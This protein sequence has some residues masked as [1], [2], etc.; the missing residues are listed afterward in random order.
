[1]VTMIQCFWVEYLDLLPFSVL[2]RYTSPGPAA[3]DL[4]KLLPSAS[5]HHYEPAHA[6]KT[7]CSSGSSCRSIRH[8]D[9]K[10]QTESNQV[11]T[12]EASFL[13]E[14]KSHICGN[15]DNPKPAGQDQNQPA[16]VRRVTPA[17]GMQLR[18]AT[19]R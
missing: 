1:M 16:R 5:A 17:N 3:Q 9:S 6:R 4:L 13:A 8:I 12:R 7:P 14:W 10:C 11:N 2:N 15:K 18:N 19:S